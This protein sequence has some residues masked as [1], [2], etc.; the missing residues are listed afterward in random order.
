[1]K[2]QFYQCVGNRMRILSRLVDAQFRVFLKEYDI[3]ENQLTILFFLD[4]VKSVD[5]GMIGKKLVLE[6]STVSRNIR[7]L[8]KNGLVKKSSD[9][10]PII[11]PTLSGIKLVKE[12]RPKWENIM[13]NLSGQL[14]QNGIHALETL[15]EKLKI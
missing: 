12:L 11:T 9:Y 7:L 13:D 14:G 15:E 1:M 4:A 3:T 6:R 2:Y 5:Q 8:E 10:R